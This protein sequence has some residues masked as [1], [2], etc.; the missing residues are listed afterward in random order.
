MLWPTTHVRFSL[1]EFRKG[2]LSPYSAREPVLWWGAWHRSAFP[3]LAALPALV[4]E[5]GLLLRK[6]LSY[7]SD[8][9]KTQTNPGS[10]CSSYR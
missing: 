4:L 7:R 8:G 2:C 3:A 6:V 9:K 1:E 5:P 10:F